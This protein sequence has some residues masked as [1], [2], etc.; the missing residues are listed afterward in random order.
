M[1]GGTRKKRR[2]RA[3]VGN[4][5]KIPPNRPLLPDLEWWRVG[6]GNDVKISRNVW[7]SHPILSHVHFNSLH[8]FTVFRCLWGKP[9]GHSGRG[10]SCQSIHLRSGGLSVFTASGTVVRRIRLQDALLRG[11][12][13]PRVVREGVVEWASLEAAMYPSLPHSIY[14]ECLSRATVIRKGDRGLLPLDWPIT[15]SYLF[16]SI[17]PDSMSVS[18]S[19]VCQA[20]LS[21]QE[22]DRKQREP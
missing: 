17:E 16:T 22:G 1:A 11:L 9:V 5:T 4:N 8:K 15:M 10:N 13:L 20:V 2:C 7:S 3:V 6:S 18:L 19:G 21:K 14:V 12:D